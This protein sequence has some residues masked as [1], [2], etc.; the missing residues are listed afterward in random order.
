MSHTVVKAQAIATGPR[1]G[2]EKPVRLLPIPLSATPAE[3]QALIDRHHNVY[4]GPGNYGIGNLRLEKG[5]KGLIWGAG[6]LTTT[7]TG[8][9]TISGSRELVLGNFN[10]SHTAAK[11]AAVIEVVGKAAADLTLLNTLVSAGNGGVGIRVKAPGRFTIQGCNPKWSDIG[12]SIEHPAAAV[13]VFGGNL[14]YNRLHIQQVQ[15]HLDAR[16]FGMQ[17]VR[18]EADIVI[19]SPSPGGYH[20]L[21]GIRTEGNNSANAIEAL[22]NVP[23]TNE[24]VN[25]MLR[26][27]TLGN[28]VRYAN[29][30]ANGNLILLENANLPGP[31]DKS[32]VGV[33]T[34]ERAKA[35]I[36]S[37]GNKYGL[38]YDEAQ[39]PFLVGK[40]TTVRSI[41]D[42]WMLPNKTDYTKPFNEPITTAAMS[43]AGKTVSSN[44]SFLAP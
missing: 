17:G 15:G 28:M 9:I 33:T 10:L 11:G 36:I 1:K 35:N 43:R 24:K 6:R 19:R 18:G 2:E 21:E 34:E 13:Y 37:L 23:Q 5:Q 39:G 8:S 22:L 30:G 31:E 40:R 3:I 26:A 20:V 4:F 38:S 42:L 12:I 29:Y 44:S 25:V 27:N 7:L 32:S 16:A 14:Q 41:G